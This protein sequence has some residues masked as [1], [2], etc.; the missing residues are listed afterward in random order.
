MTFPPFKRWGPLV[1]TGALSNP[2]FPPDL[3]LKIPS[4]PDLLDPGETFPV[5]LRKSNRPV[6]KKQPEF[7]LLLGDNRSEYLVYDDSPFLK[8][9]IVNAEI[10][11]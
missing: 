1:I 8:R 4:D 5:I 6:R 2:G 3:A 9:N 7:D 11:M 10:K